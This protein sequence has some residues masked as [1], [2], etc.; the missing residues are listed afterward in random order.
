MLPV[1]RLDAQ[2][3]TG[4]IGSVAGVTVFLAFLLFA[5][6]MTAQLSTATTVSAVGYDAARAVASR[7]VDHADPVAVARAQVRAEAQ[8]RRL[9]GGTGGQA[10]FAWT[11]DADSVRLRLGAR[12]PGILPP[13]W[14]GMTG[15]GWI[16]RTFAVRIEQTR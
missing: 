3:G 10:R 14:S 1:A 9:L 4:V 8:G 6:Q 16:E 2:E 5:V 13:G 12:V 11:I 7:R 15:P